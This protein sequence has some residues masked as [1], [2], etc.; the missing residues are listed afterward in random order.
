MSKVKLAAIPDVPATIDP[1]VAKV[2]RAAKEILEIR[3]GRRPNQSILDRYVTFR[4]LTDSPIGLLGLGKGGSFYPVTPGGGTEGPG[5]RH[6]P[7]QPTGVTANGAF[8]S[9]IVAWDDP[10]T[11]Y[12]NHAYTEIWR[13]S[14]N[15]RSQATRVGTSDSFVWPDQRVQP[16]PTYYYWVRFVSTSNVIGPYNAGP[17]DGIAAA[18]ALD[19]AYVLDQLTT[20]AWTVDTYYSAFA[21]VGPSSDVVIDGV[22]VAF[23]AQNA[24]TSGATEPNWSSV[25]TIG[26]TITDGTITWAA[27]DA[28]KAPFV[29][30]SINGHPVVYM[31]GAVLED[32]S[33]TNEKIET[34]AAD[35]IL[36]VTGTLAE[37]F[38][39]TGDITNA[40]IGNVIQSTN[41]QSGSHG[42]LINKSGYAEFHELTIYDSSGNV[43]L[44]SGSGVQP[45]SSFPWDAITGADKPD[46][47]ADVTGSNTAN[48][49][50]TGGGRAVSQHGADV[51]GSNT[52]AAIAGQGNFATLD[53]ITPS[54]ISTYMAGVAIG[55][56]YIAHAAVDTL[57]IAGRAVTYPTA[58]SWSGSIGNGTGTDWVAL[59]SKS[60]NLV[61]SGDL[62]SVIV[63]AYTYGNGEF[64]TRIVRNSTVVG[65]LTRVPIFTYSYNGPSNVLTSHPHSLSIAIFIDTP[66]WGN[67][68]YVAQMS[69]SGTALVGGM[70]II[71]AKR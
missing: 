12:A 39:G 31:P 23:Q 52:A 10:L 24:G 63:I 21:A 56:A 6:K 42:W 58:V 36:A 16:G 15:D 62:P 71:G 32:L 43:I 46:D 66:G 30:G 20:Q 26:G 5:N 14:V 70:A 67:H 49:V 61:G 51:T 29:T 38:I 41:Y 22:T 9:V 2:L 34:L 25:T 27:I 60:I 8:S 1:G 19:P 47:N 54:N 55:T 37:A 13:A 17:T 57:Q 7:P 45:P 44:S 53:Q 28:H 3:E 33:V 50:L 35:K 69:S 18:V 68:N 64:N 48:D 11:L 65:Q 40:M 59:F 4:D